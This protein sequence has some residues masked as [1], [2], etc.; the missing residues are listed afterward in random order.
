MSDD[1]N[2]VD[3]ENE[4]GAF[5]EAESSAAPRKDRRAR[6]KSLLTFYISAFAAVV[7]GA[8]LLCVFVF[9]RVD[10]VTIIGGGSYRQEDILSI[11]NINE[12][13]NLVLLSTGGA[14]KSLNTASRISRTWRSKRKYP[15]R[16][17]L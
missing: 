16:L 5:A 6:N 11:C 1:F 12:G 9:F 13:D 4:E 15:R 10:S 3:T 2:S 14:R 7:V 8:V 17:R